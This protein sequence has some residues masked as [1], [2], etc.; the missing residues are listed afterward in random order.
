MSRKT[1]ETFHV[2]FDDN[3]LRES[4]IS[5]I[6]C[7]TDSDGP[8]NLQDSDIIEPEEIKR[9]MKR[10]YVTDSSELFG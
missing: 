9:V 7:I 6:V 4:E 3:T 1:N 2:E 5:E 10:F 8:R